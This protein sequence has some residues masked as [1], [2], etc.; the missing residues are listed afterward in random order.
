MKK[1]K[2]S[3]W[4]LSKYAD[5]RYEHNQVFDYSK[6]MRSIIIDDVMS[7]GY[8]VMLRSSDSQLII[9]IDRG[10]FGQS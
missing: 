1:I 10:R 2:V 9:Y 8:S 3:Y 7:K 4:H 5:L 6:R